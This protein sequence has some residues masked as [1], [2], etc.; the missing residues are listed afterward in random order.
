MK[1]KSRKKK[2]ADRRS[3]NKSSA[4]HVDDK[5]H[6]NPNTQQ[7]NNT[8][9]TTNR[10][11]KGMKEWLNS[12]SYESLVNALEF[13]FQITFQI[14]EGSSGGGSA[15]SNLSTSQQSHDLCED[16]RSSSG[17]HEF[18]LLMEMMSS[19]QSPDIYDD[20]SCHEWRRSIRSK[21]QAPC[22]FRWD[23][24]SEKNNTNI[25]NNPPTKK[26]AHTLDSSSDPL[27]SLL[28]ETAG[29]PSELLDVLAQAGVKRSTSA[30][31]ETFNEV[32]ELDQA[33]ESL[34]DCQSNMMKN[35]D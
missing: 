9:T 32:D 30:L 23:T 7:T 14:D 5:V 24:D 33:F 22:F 20:E 19:F 29:L 26:E 17:S 11:L 3:K 4:K 35:I 10:D 16:E 1:N 34:D 6:I 13:T 28:G 15:V 18:D 21:L 8:S 31:L 12:L 25:N 27:A 2:S